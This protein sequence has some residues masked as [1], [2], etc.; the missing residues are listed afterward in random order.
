MIW[1]IG[2]II[3]SVGQN[4][5]VAKVGSH[6]ITYD[7][8]AS[9]LQQEVSRI[10][11]MIKGRVTPAQL[12]E[13]GLHQQ[14]LD[15]LINQAVLEQELEKSNLS[16]SD[17][18]VRN[19]IH[20]MPIFQQDGVFNRQLFQDLLKH[21]NLRESGFLDN[22]KQ[23]LLGQQLLVPLI[24]GVS[25]PAFYKEILFKAIN[26][27]KNLSV[28]LFPLEKIKLKKNPTEND[29]KLYYSQKKEHYKVNERR[30]ISLVLI[31]AKDLLNQIPI[32]EEEIKQEYQKQKDQF[33]KPE[34]R[35]V[36]SLTY[37]TEEKALHAAKLINSGKPIEIVLRQHAGGKF[38]DL[39]TVAKSDLAE[40]AADVV[41]DLEL[42]RSSE[43]VNTGFGYVIYQV[44][45]IEPKALQSL[46]EARSQI[47]ENLRL[48]KFGD[49]FQE[50]RNKI[51]DS[52]AGGAKLEEV[53]RANQLK[54]EVIPAF[55]GSGQTEVKSSVLEFLSA[56]VKKQIIEQTFN[57]DEN[58]QS[59]VIE[60]DPQ[61]FFILQVDK[62][63]PSYVPEFETIK[64]NIEKDVVDERKYEEARQ[65]IHAF[66]Q[67]AKTIDDL[68]LFASQNGLI[69]KENQTISRIDLV[70]SQKDKPHEL[71][72]MLGA[73]LLLKAL[74]TPLNHATA[75]IITKERKF[76]VIMP[77][78]IEP[79]KS[80]LQKEDKF[81]DALKDAVQK[82]IIDLLLKSF[83]MHFKVS[84]NQDLIDSMIQDAAS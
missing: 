53:A 29:L 69:I 24:G 1:G 3:R 18:L 16:V 9:A 34:R 65:L 11:Q 81:G 7:E 80:D 64:A 58:A 57:T 62:I 79:F 63:Q 55:D 39:G 68:K 71:L 22:V 35:Y 56:D 5:P 14:V 19:Q 66:T 28:V 8:Y 76:A 45:K 82:D 40:V 72:T 70:E 42:N 51:E 32:T 12:K 49:A 17:S 52:L 4:R 60:A 6:S 31:S 33:V 67:K 61:T 25:L 13:I 37:N 10:Q 30:L 15:Q 2:D 47:Q 83:R 46:S 44:I 20:S 54:V 50:L 48:Q 75:G 59:A 74:Q 26:E 73:E 41:F 27:K 43:V 77:C 23:S 38:D 36:K 84:I 21:N 78:R